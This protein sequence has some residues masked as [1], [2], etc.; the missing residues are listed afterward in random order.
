VRPPV[1]KVSSAL[2]MKS[3]LRF[4]G[5]LLAVAA[6]GASLLVGSASAVPGAYRVLIVFNNDGPPKQLQQQIAAEPGVAAVDIYE[7]DVGVPVPNPAQLASYDLV[8]DVPDFRYDDEVSYGNALADY[9]DAGGVL[10]QFAYDSWSDGG[11]G[12]GPEG[13]FSSG[14][15]AP[16]VPGEN[17]NDAL[18]LGSFD[19]ANPLM[20]GVGPLT[21]NDNT[22]PGLAPG[23]TLV[24]Q[25]DNGVPAIAYKGS[26]VSVSAYTGGEE[27]DGTGEYGRLAVN[28]VRWLG[29]QM[30]SVT[31][32]SPTG[33]IVSS[34]AGGILCSPHCTA[35][36]RRLTPVTLVAGPAKGYA[37]AGFG[38]ACGGPTCNL[39]MDAPKSVSA[40]FYAFGGSKKLKR[41]KRK[42]TASLSFAI[43]GPGT[44][45][46]TG[47]RVKKRSKAVT[48]AGRIAIPIAAKGKARKAL[49]ENGKVKVGLRV[50]FTPTGGTAASF[51]KAATLRLALD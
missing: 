49:G 32:A 43:G 26:V 11:E 12:N 4:F 37:F 45:T 24:A 38:G 44:V 36:V 41:N 35:F 7:A 27:F 10:V 3:A 29:A 30:L 1:C 39:T 47:K 40:N 34:S 42:G 9:L 14:G 8:V 28:A 51:T 13:R 17:E 25:W 6:L 31:N 48:K 19:A 18:T 22:A 15:Y 20:Q 16:F 2:S 46:V 23:A 5:A 21:S 50:T 33:G